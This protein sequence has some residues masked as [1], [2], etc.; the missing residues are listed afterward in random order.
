MRSALYSHAPLHNNSLGYALARH[1]RALARTCAPLAGAGQT[2]QHGVG[3]A[4]FAVIL[5]GAVAY[6]LGPWRVSAQRSEEELKVPRCAK[7]D[8]G[9]PKGL[10]GG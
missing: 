1:M 9:G 3:R 6:F 2:P 4:A 5:M 8:R 7:T 10:G